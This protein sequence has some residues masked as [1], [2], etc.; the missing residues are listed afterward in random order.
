MRVNPS[1]QLLI[2]KS[3]PAPAPALPQLAL[4]LATSL[5]PPLRLPLIFNSIRDTPLA[6]PFTPLSLLFH[7]AAAS[8][9]TAAIYEKAGTLDAL[10]S[11]KLPFVSKVRRRQLSG[12]HLGWAVWQWGWC[13][14]S[15]RQADNQRRVQ[16]EGRVCQL[17][18]LRSL[19]PGLALT[20]ESCRRNCQHTRRGHCACHRRR[21]RRCRST[22]AG[23]RQIAGQGADT[24][25]GGGQGGA[26]P[27]PVAA[28]GSSGGLKRLLLLE[29]W[30][31]LVL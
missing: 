3:R 22:T 16:R 26:H 19:T 2:L 28:A 10:K 1:I 9:L 30:W 12:W 15:S 18:S 8:T 14:C 17:T 13:G 27:G 11:L 23:Q 24:G 31:V 7:P 21:R 5:A 6:Q 29:G 20:R 25:G 4:P